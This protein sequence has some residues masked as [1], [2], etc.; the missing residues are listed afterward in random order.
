MR[1]S[2]VCLLLCFSTEIIA[3]SASYHPLLE[4][5]KTWTY[6]Y[7]NFFT[8]QSYMKTLAIGEDTVINNVGYRKIFDVATGQYEYALREDGKKVFARFQNGNSEV[9]LYDFGHDVGDVFDRQEDTDGSGT[10]SAKKV[11]AV[12]MLEVNGRQFRRMKVAEYVF[13]PSGTPENEWSDYE[14]YDSYWIEGVGSTS[15]L[16]TP[17]PYLGNCYSLVSWQVDGM[18]YKLKDVTD[19]IG[20]A[21]RMGAT[22]NNKVEMIN[23]KDVFDLQGR[24]INSDMVKS[25]NGQIRPGVYIRNGKK[26]VKE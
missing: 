11:L 23:D 13:L 6:L 10:F 1:K 4:D 16:E 24:R 26:I 14:Y 20:D 25:S 17:I 7:S 9:T 18:T 3:Q 12:D 5:G 2:I 19:G 21:P 15:I 22:L 8:A